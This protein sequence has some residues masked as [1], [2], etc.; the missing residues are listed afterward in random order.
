[1][2]SPGAYVGRLLGALRDRL[3]LRLSLTRIQPNQI[4]LLGVALSAAA[5][6][7]FAQLAEGWAGAVLLGAGTCD[8]LAGAL[9]RAKGKLTTFGAIYDSTLNHY[10][11]FFIFFG[12]AI[13]G[14]RALRADRF[15][16]ALA[17]TVGAV[18]TSYVRARAER[19]IER[20]D[21]GFTERPERLVAIIVGALIGHLDRA[22]WVLV[23]LTHLTV[24]QRL[25]YTRHALGPQQPLPS[26]WRRMLR[27]L[28]LW[29]YPRMSWQYDLVAGCIMALLIVPWPLPLGLII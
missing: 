3:A 25:L 21:V 22:L 11:D 26:G 24:I 1:M 16:L 13:G 28:L 5:G 18:L 4:T 19:H 6:F 29:P 17:V 20:C 15:G 12:I 23:P 7:L 8:V 27:G 9:A 14:L 2:D 10:S